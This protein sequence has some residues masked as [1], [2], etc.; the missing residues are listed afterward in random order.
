ML[1]LL[2]FICIPNSWVVQIHASQSLIKHVR[3]KELFNCKVKAWIKY[4]GAVQIE[5]S[6]H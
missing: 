2:H 4:L 6:N 5:G 3:S 1:I